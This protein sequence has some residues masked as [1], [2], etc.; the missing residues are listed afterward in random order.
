MTAAVLPWAIIAGAARNMRIHFAE[1][2]FLLREETMVPLGND[3]IDG[4]LTLAGG[5][6]G[7]SYYGLQGCIEGAAIG[8]LIG[9]GVTLV[10]G[11]YWHKYTFP[12]GHLLKIGTATLAMVAVIRYVPVMPTA[13]SLGLT[14]SAGAAVYA[15]AMMVLYPDAARQAVERVRRRAGA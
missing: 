11:A 4:A 14:V 9:L 8:A 6:L 2:V 10:S 1:Q 12:L 5:A 3:V 13:L 7:L 15:V